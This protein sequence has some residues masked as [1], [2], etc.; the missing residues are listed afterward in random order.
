[1]KRPVVSSRFSLKT[2]FVMPLPTL[3]TPRE[4]LLPLWMLSMLWR[5][6]V[7]P[8]TVSVDKS[9][10]LLLFICLNQILQYDTLQ[11]EIP[12]NITSHFSLQSTIYK[13]THFEINCLFFYKIFILF[14][15]HQLLYFKRHRLLCLLQML[16][17]VGF[18]VSLNMSS[19][20]GYRW[21]GRC[22]AKH[23]LLVLMMYVTTN[24]ALHY[25][26]QID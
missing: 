20:T 8:F 11:H 4:R 3:N 15:F 7:V 5:D 26:H 21:E 2:L 18:V 9:S 14:L 23:N 19:Y 10:S 16:L 24:I 13:K 1:M 6:K 17:Y 25:T 12:R 22:F